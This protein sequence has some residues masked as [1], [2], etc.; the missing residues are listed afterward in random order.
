MR[1]LFEIDT[2]NYKENGTVL[3]RPS[4]RG[5]IIKDNKLA[6]IHSLKY[7]YYK[8]PGGGI[9]PGENRLEALCREVS[10]ESG[11]TVIRSSVKEYGLVHRKQRGL[12]EDIFIQDNFYYLCDVE[13]K[14]SSQELDDYEDEELFT[15]EWVDPFTAL[16]TNINND[17]GDKV[18]QVTFA[19]M[20]SRECR[21]LELLIS[22][23][24]FRGKNGDE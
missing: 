4:A 11:L 13:D 12:H 1:L 14:V 22:E 19:S 15:L 20:C 17:H 2:K 5:I 23:G 3:V 10:E 16:R 24:Y 7:D 6:M 18:E 9:E 21:V 8:F